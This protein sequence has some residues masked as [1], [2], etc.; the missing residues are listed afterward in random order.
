MQFILIVYSERWATETCFE[1]LKAYCT[2]CFFMAMNGIAEAYVFSKGNSDT[3]KV[4]RQLMMVNSISYIG[5]SYLF[6]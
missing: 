2:Y 4:L 6:S 3:L 1:L 5:M